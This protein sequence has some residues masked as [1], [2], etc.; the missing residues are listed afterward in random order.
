VVVEADNLILPGVFAIGLLGGLL[1][2]W[3]PMSG[4]AA[5]AFPFVLPA[6]GIWLGIVF[7]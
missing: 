1:S 5:L 2:R 7:C 3:M 6:V 4:W